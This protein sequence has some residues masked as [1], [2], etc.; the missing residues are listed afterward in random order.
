M[1]DEDYIKPF[2]ARV[3]QHGE[4]TVCS[5]DE[6]QAICA[7]HM[8]DTEFEKKQSSNPAVEAISMRSEAVTDALVTTPM[9]PH[10]D[11]R[12]MPASEWTKRQKETPQLGAS[13][14]SS[15][16]RAVPPS[17]F[18]GLETSRFNGF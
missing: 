12:M 5:N 6:F 11:L 2:L 18:L 17:I 4:K 10:T 15:N 14:K 13:G 8:A 1:P 7:Y 16:K 9:S 3:Q